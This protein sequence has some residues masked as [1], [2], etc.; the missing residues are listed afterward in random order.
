[1]H[2]VMVLSF[3]T[4]SSY[5]FLDPIVGKVPCLSQSFKEPA[6]ALQ[7]RWWPGPSVLEP[8]PV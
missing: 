3:Q 1:M 7:E 5:P 6:R 4:I 2:R 8:A